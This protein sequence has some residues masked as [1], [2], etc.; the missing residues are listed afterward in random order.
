MNW[1][2]YAHMIFLLRE[3]NLCML[4]GSYIYPKDMKRRLIL[5]KTI[6]PMKITNKFTLLLIKKLGLLGK[7]LFF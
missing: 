6:F 1:K 4:R 3:Q 5:K 2:R 7:I